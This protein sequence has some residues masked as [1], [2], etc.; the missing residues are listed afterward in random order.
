MV[1]YY[2]RFVSIFFGSVIFSYCW[3]SLNALLMMILT[4]NGVSTVSGH[5]IIIVVGLPLIGILVRSLR[6]M[7]IESLMKV[8]IEKLGS[9]IDAL[10]Q[11]AKMTDFSRGKN[12]D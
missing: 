1:P 12:R 10:I 5:I 8:N 6:E 7:R 2:N 3:I 4:V 11:V 9:D